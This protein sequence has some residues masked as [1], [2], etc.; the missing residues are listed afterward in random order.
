[1]AYYSRRGERIIACFQYQADSEEQY[2]QAKVIAEDVEPST[3]QVD[4]Q[5]FG[6]RWKPLRLHPE[7]SGY[8]DGRN[9]LPPLYK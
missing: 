7:A 1:M 2:F 3:R 8:V 9:V 6:N 5:N 4:S